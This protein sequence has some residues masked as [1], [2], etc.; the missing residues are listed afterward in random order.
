[1]L[2][3]KALTYKIIVLLAGEPFGFIFDLYV[4]PW[5]SQPAESSYSPIS[6]C[7][8]NQSGQ[9]MW[10]ALTTVGKLKRGNLS[11]GARE[12]WFGFD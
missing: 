12:G 6:A 10:A 7:D 2:K 11:V 5:P 9:E 3:Q 8:S 4:P 1:M